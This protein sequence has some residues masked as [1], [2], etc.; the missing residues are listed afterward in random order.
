MNSKS[1]RS[2]CRHCGKIFT[3]DYRNH[4]HQQYCPDPDCRRTSKA[5]SQR[6]WL[7]QAKNR[8]YFH[9]PEQTQRV[10]EWRKSNPDYWK[11]K[12][13]VPPKTSANE[14]HTNDQAQKSCNAP[15]SLPGPLQDVCFTRSPLFIGLISAIAGSTLQED[16]AA[17]I[18]ELQTQ[19]RKI[20]K[21]IPSD[22]YNEKR[23]PNNDCQE[24]PS[25]G[26]NFDQLWPAAIHT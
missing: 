11:Q 25:P 17:T 12:P 16:I 15:T 24:C 1:S 13:T 18:R 10:Q 7:R 22:Q 21:P 4:Y 6:R 9:G 5:V 23:C 14:P 8:D 2:K 3:P 20:L 19:G 26:A